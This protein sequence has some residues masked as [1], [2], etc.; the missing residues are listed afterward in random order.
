[1][2][3][4]A[5]ARSAG[6]TFDLPP[7][8][9]ELLD[10][11]PAALAATPDGRLVVADY[12]CGGW[13]RA[14]R[15]PVTARELAGMDPYALLARADGSVWFAAE[16]SETGGTI[17]RVAPDGTLTR[18][19]VPRPPGELAE[20]PDGSVW[21][22]DDD[23]CRLYRVS[24]DRS[25][26]ARR[27]SSTGTCA[28]RPTAACGWPGTPASTHL[29]A[30]EL[31]AATPPERCDTTGPR[32]TLPDRARIAAER[33]RRCAGAACGC[34]RTRPD[35]WTSS[36]SRPAAG[37]R[38]SSSASCGADGRS[39]CGSRRMAAP[40]RREPHHRRH[41]HRRRRQLGDLPRTV[42]LGP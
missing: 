25:S 31:A 32:V 26:D 40:P 39:R 20:A 5:T 42:K 10:C 13:S 4:A 37:R 24:G 38:A 33:A 19:D 41:D 17:G 34:G 22:A 8:P 16:N 2:R 29:S 27:R 14:T 12:G 35:I 1:M 3:V 7:G 6:A 21:A 28:S 18:F 9:I 23:A 36:C 30:A 11:E 15:R